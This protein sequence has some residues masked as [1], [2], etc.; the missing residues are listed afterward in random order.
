MNEA[1]AQAHAK[2]RLGEVD[3]ALA[4]VGPRHRWR[5]ALEAW[6]WH[7]DPA[8]GRLPAFSPPPNTEPGAWAWMALAVARAHLLAGDRE[9]ARPWLA[10]LCGLSSP[11]RLRD[12]VRVEVSIDAWLGGTSAEPPTCEDPDGRIDQVVVRALS[13]AEED[14]VEQGL[15]LARRASRMARTEAA[16]QRQ[17]FANLALARLRRLDGQPVLASRIATA[18][19]EVAPEAWHPWLAW[20]LLMAGATEAA[21]RCVPDRSPARRMMGAIEAAQAG[22]HHALA[23]QLAELRAHSLPVPLRRDADAACSMLDPA[24][25]PAHAHPWIVGEQVGAPRGLLAMGA[26]IRSPA[27]AFVLAIPGQRPRRVLSVS[28]PL[29]PEAERYEGRGR[30]ESLAACVLLAGDTGIVESE[31]FES[32]YGF[33]FKPG[34]H[35]GA[36]RVALHRASKTLDGFGL[37]RDGERVRARVAR[38][39]AV[40]DPRCEPSQHGRVLK[41]LA[42]RRGVGA[43]EVASMLGI[44]LRNAQRTLASLRDDG[45]CTAVGRGPMTTYAVEDTTFSEPTVSGHWKP[46]RS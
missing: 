10:S 25:E 35:S 40:R 37:E 19:A 38:P 2:L 6:V 14:R 30:V 23:A 29:A 45:W 31:L 28:L 33:R 1:F 9:A 11:P 32:V 39:L 5:A 24:R 36:L 3:E 18:I 43:R 26:T 17:Y 15:Q 22:D 46:S 27:A 8:R 13:T 41:L 16:P 4:T 7:A 12:A 20:E 42:E 44:P 34:T 21:Q